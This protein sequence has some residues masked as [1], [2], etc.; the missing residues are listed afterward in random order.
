VTLSL[1][2]HSLS[3]APGIRM[4]ASARVATPSSS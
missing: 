1:V 2:L 4:Q 3:T